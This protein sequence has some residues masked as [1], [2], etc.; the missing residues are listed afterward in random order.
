MD[1]FR[2]RDDQSPVRE[3]ERGLED[4]KARLGKF[5]R[6]PLTWLIILLVLA[7]YLAS[8]FYVVGPAERGVV[9]LFG[10]VFSVTEPGLRYRLPRPF[11]SA[12]VVDTQ[13]IRRVEIGF[14][15]ERGVTRSV[16]AESLMLTGDEQ[17]V[18]VHL[19]VQYV[20]QDPIKFL[21][22]SYQPDNVIRAS[23]EV[24]LRGVVGE[25]TID[26]TMTLGRLEVQQKVQPYL[27][28]LLDTYQTGLR[29]TETKL[30]VVDPPGQVKEAFHDVVRALEDRDRLVKEAEGYR[31]D[32]L[33][34]ARGQAIQVVQE[35][36]AYK[37]ERV[38]RARGDAERF[39]TVLNEYVNSREVTR[40]RL[41]LETVER[42]LPSTKLYLIDN[43]ESGVMPLLPLLQRGETVIPTPPTEEPTA[44]GPSKPVPKK[45]R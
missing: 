24:A 1:Q 28:R 2:P 17:V 21:F 43:K 16:P 14:R 3:I 41:Y 15:S 18:D 37:A 23:A 44:A 36:E 19:I 32:I 13:T 25:N 40:E 9:L 10:K 22:G 35:A 31:E 39:I 26:F 6:G 30:L 27:Q 34:K 11:M 12:T 45:G 33:P 38:M 5:M 20:V 7:F 8:G 4:L 29:V 42:F